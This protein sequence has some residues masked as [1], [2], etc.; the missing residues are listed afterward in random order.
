MDV[1]GHVKI[2][3]AIILGLGVADLAAWSRWDRAPS[4]QEPRLPGLSGL[5]AIRFLV[6]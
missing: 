5:G 6:P 1:Y 3:F 4:Q 2:L